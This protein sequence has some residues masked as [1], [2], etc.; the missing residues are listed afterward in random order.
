[1]HLQAAPVAPPAPEE[2]ISNAV[3]LTDVS[4]SSLLDVVTPLDSQE[5]VQHTLE[6]E[7][8]QAAVYSPNPDSGADQFP[9][10]I[11]AVSDPSG[12]TA[13]SRAPGILQSLNKHAKQDKQQL[14]SSKPGKATALIMDSVTFKAAFACTACIF[15]ASWLQF[16]H[17][18]CEW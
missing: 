6:T 8:R 17:C 2:A 15:D 7:Q 14:A 11:A 13:Q 16:W 10:Q 12:N 9:H 18:M 1:M 5:D 4:P 3:P